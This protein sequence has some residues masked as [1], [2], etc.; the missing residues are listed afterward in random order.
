MAIDI[1]NFGDCHT[2]ILTYVRLRVGIW[3]FD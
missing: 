1:T 2:I 3:D